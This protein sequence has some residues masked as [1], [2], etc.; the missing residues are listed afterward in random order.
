[1][2]TEKSK[3]IHSMLFPAIFLVVLWLVKIFEVSSG[4]DLRFL[5]IYP[6]KVKGLIG[7]LTSPLIHGDFSH[8]SANSLPVFI[9]STAIF[10]FY[11][12]ISYKVF[13]LI[14]FLS[15]LWVWFGGREAYHI[16]ASSLI[17]GMGAFL[18]VSGIIRKDT[19]LMAVSMIVIFAYGGL[20]WGIF[21]DFFP[22]KNISWEGH[23]MGLIAGVILAV[24][25]RRSGPKR[26]MYSWEF[27]EVDDDDD[28]DNPNGSSLE[29]N[30]LEI[31]YH[32]TEKKDE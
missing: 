13:F 25:F 23:L 22:E 6:L 27:E 15:G 30:S 19:R 1:M 3:I 12:G 2:N 16:G 8:L 21:P 4:I 20:I 5:G 31:N 26:K 14:Y 17:Y 32:Y 7:I 24:Y 18:F 11:K 10:Y 9:L 29:D 28:H